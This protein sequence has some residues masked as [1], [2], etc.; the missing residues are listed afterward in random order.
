MTAHLP[1]IPLP[2]AGMKLS[3]VIPCYNEVELIEQVIQAVLD[4]PY[5]NKEVIVVD[6]ASNDG[7]ADFLAIGSDDT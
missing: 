5:P 1:E 2:A 7:S 4:A 3:I 6:D